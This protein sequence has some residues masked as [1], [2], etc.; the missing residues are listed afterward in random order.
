VSS[1]GSAKD[2]DQDLDGFDNYDNNDGDDEEILLGAE[3]P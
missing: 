3:V 1:A 2:L